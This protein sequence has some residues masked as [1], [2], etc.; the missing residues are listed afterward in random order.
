MVLR[1]EAI[2]AAPAVEQLLRIAAAGMRQLNGL[3]GGLSLPELQRDPSICPEADDR[4]D[5]GTVL[6]HAVIQL[7]SP[8]ELGRCAEQ[9]FSLRAAA[10]VEG[11]SERV[12][13]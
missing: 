8:L 4:F 13:T 3:A 1:S 6:V 12:E 11:V 5:T 2:A 9:F 7:V 10:G